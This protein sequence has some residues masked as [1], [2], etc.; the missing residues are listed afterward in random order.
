MPVALD[1]LDERPDAGERVDRVA[2]HRDALGADV[3][4][5][6][7]PEV[8][9]REAEHLEDEVEDRPEREVGRQPDAELAEAAEEPRD[10]AV[11][12]VA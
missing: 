9:R 7:L 11:E 2:D 12:Q 4:G 6:L 5:E 10:E 3:L 1:V 8:L